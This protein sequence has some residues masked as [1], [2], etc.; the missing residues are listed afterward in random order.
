MFGI[1][2]FMAGVIPATAA[3]VNVFRLFTADGLVVEGA[4]QIRG[5]NFME[6]IA[7]ILLVSIFLV[8][9]GYIL[10]KR[11]F[12]ALAV[13]NLFCIM[14]LETCMPSSGIPFSV[15]GQTQTNLVYSSVYS[16]AVTC[17]G[18]VALGV[19]LWNKKKE[20]R[21]ESGERR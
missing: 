17:P 7:S 5:S 6:S 15:G 14:L 13:L 19:Y 4:G 1:W 12:M 11:I 8:I 9:C 16:I 20:E 3:V 18:Y 10:Q 2:G 21:R